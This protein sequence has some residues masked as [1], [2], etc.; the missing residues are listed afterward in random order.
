MDSKTPH[1]LG[2]H[3]N[4]KGLRVGT[5]LAAATPEADMIATHAAAPPAAAAATT[6]A[7]RLTKAAAVDPA[8]TTLAR[9]PHD[10][11]CPSA[12][13]SAA[14]PPPLLPLG[15]ALDRCGR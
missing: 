10:K 7:P 2:N 9:N 6:K 14:V 12:Y 13:L 8:G 3:P 4:N 15:E 1:R 11:A 5:I